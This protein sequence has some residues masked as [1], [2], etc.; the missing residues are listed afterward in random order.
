M[1]ILGVCNGKGPPAKVIRLAKA[2]APARVLLL[3]WVL[4]PGGQAAAQGWI[5]SAGPWIGVAA[6]TSGLG[7]EGGVRPA[8]RLGVRLGMGW[9]PYKPQIDDD[10]IT[11]RVYFPSP[12]TR[13]TLDVFP[14]GGTFHLSTG[15]HRYSGG[16]TARARAR[17][18]VEVNDREYT[19]E[20]LGEA[21]GKVWG[22]ET[23]PYLGI[24][25][26]GRTWRAGAYIDFGVAFTGSPLMSVTVTGPIG[27]D[28]TF[29]SDLDAEL[30]DAE[31]SISSY[32]FFPHIAAG[33]RIR[34]GP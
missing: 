13:L 32:R 11:G 8:D 27:N 9:I 33:L 23:A 10:D 28:A 16:I 15:F 24:G 18:S 30:R 7:L 5:E 22:R 3:A 14:T 1:K 29:R 12:I 19:P 2:L 25:W 6:G 31:D 17:D 20:E 26:I 34:L 4:V 21:T